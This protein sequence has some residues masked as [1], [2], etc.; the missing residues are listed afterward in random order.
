MPT[1]PRR[2]VRSRVGG[3]GA[4][5]ISALRQTRLDRP[6]R[7][8][9][10]WS[11]LAGARPLLRGTC[12]QSG[13]RST[14]NWNSADDAAGR[15]HGGRCP[16]T[17]VRRRSSATRRAVAGAATPSSLNPSGHGRPNEAHLNARRHRAGRRSWPALAGDCSACRR[18]PLRRSPERWWDSPT[19]NR[20]AITPIEERAPRAGATEAPIRS[21]R[22][23]H[24]GVLGTRST[25]NQT[26]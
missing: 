9:N 4:R 26:R 2:S 19:G 7:A 23:V 24:R 3:S 1:L 8:D 21:V 11:N 6:H 15:W 22:G 20:D 5:G 14:R 25:G 12:E 17:S 18:G 13:N 16:A 10:G